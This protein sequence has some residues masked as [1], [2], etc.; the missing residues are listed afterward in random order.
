[1]RSVALAIGA[2]LA[3]AAMLALVKVVPRYDCI[4][5]VLFLFFI[6]RELDRT[7]PGLRT[8]TLHTVT[9]I[10]MSAFLVHLWTLGYE[11]RNAVF[12]GVL[13]WSDSHDYY[14]DSLRLV[15][16]E[17]FLEVGSKRP[18]Y[19]VALAGLLRITNGDLRACFV[20]MA[21]VGAWATAVA[22]L[23]V[24]KTHGWKSAL[25]VYLLLLFIERRW[26]GFVQTEHF[27]LPLGAI[28]FALLWRAHYGK[29]P[30]PRAPFMVLAALFALTLALVAR[31]GSFFVLPAIAIWAGLRFYRH[32]IRRLFFI[33]LAANVIMA[34]FVMNRAVVSACGS[35][36]LFSDYPG[37]AYGM[38]HDRGFEYLG[39]EHPELNDF[40][41]E[42]RV[43]ASWAVVKSEAKAQPKL[44]AFGLLRS[45]LGLFLDPLGMFGYVWTNPDDHVLEDGAKVRAVGPI[46]LWVQELGVYSLLNAVVMGVLGAALVI[47][48]VGAVIVLYWKR[49]SDP[50][51]SLLRWAYGGILLSAP[52]LPPSITS[53]QQTQTATMAF[54][55]ALPAVVFILQS[56]KPERSSTSLA[57]APP[58][59]AALLVGIVAW[60]KLAPR[61]PPPCIPSSEPTALVRVFPRS[62]VTVVDKRS[63][64]PRKNA[65]RDLRSNF[66]LLGKHNPELVK[67]VEP[68]LKPGTRYVSAYD[69]CDRSVKILVDDQHALPA[70]ANAS[71]WTSITA[72]P[73]A[74]ASVVHVVPPNQTPE[75]PQTPVL[76]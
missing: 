40:P 17:R 32:I 11:G 5:L 29:G 55:A 45:G 42:Q 28:G 4:A 3:Y 72:L 47:A 52:F 22:A 30:N 43:Q 34:G 13:P 58:A 67:S 15:H 64:S 49:R 41:I 51:L 46:K 54:I 23:E 50:E 6:F 18:L 39:Q 35:G 27:G 24:W 26:T 76:P 71:T 36:V 1:L 73:L 21:F 14:G 60:M 8:V 59:I 44:V 48:S 7:T 12:G 74:T 65:E 25:V 61:T 2:A 57:W 19:S 70:D 31:T 10:L 37:I 68:Y 33:V 9:V 16:G 38:M 66:P 63:L 69:A 20:L 62:D 53:G 56:K 75:T